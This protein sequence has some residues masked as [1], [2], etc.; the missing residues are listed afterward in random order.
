MPSLWY[1]RR[2]Q[3]ITSW[4]ANELLS[5]REYVVV[6]RHERDGYLVSTVWL[7]LDHN[8]SGGQPLFFETM[9]FGPDGWNGDYQQRYP[10]EDAA[11]AGHDRAIAYLRNEILGGHR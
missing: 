7:G 9:I 2:G 8:Y 5:D 1:D 4:Q 10:T 3:P 6:A 11:L